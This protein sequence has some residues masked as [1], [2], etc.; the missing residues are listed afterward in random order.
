MLQAPHGLPE[1][2]QFKCC[3]PCGKKVHKLSFYP[4]QGKL[5]SETTA[6]LKSMPVNVLAMDRCYPADF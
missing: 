1:A 5:Q 2:P 6:S 3:F 4:M